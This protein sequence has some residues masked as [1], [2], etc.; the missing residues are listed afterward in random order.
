M[1]AYALIMSAPLLLQQ[2]VFMRLSSPVTIPGL[3]LASLVRAQAAPHAGP[4][5]PPSASAV[6]AAKTTAPSAA[7]ASAPS[8][9][10]I[11]IN[12]ASRDQLGALPQAGSVCA[13]AIIRGHS[14]KAKSDLLAKKAIPQNASFAIQSRIVARP[15]IAVRPSGVVA[16]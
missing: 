2:E 13:H 6:P 14:Y 7:P 1:A 10:L 9:S 12:T 15:E 4:T 11:D 16:H 5:K 8:N 3:V